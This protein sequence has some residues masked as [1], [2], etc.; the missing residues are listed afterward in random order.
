VFGRKRI[1]ALEAALEEAKTAQLRTERHRLILRDRVLSRERS[2]PARKCELVDEML[3]FVQS[4][5]AGQL[6]WAAPV[7]RERRPK[8]KFGSSWRL[9]SKWSRTPLT[10]MHSAARRRRQPRRSQSQG[11]KDGCAS[12]IFA[13]VR[14]A[15]C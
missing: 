8:L 13:E 10:R 1:A 11:S 9:S 12:R 5:V 2:F 6:D 7:S 3:P 15:A 4:L 14:G